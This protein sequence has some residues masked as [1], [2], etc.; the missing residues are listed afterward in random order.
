L[1]A[2]KKPATAKTAKQGTVI[3]H[4][5]AD[6]VVPFAHNEELVN[7]SALPV[8]ALIEVGSNHWLADPEPVAA[9]LKA[10]EGAAE[11]ILTKCAGFSSAEG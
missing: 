11:V 2:W 6:A 4:S 5:R 1:P 8:L 7:N 9:M 3:L 10:C